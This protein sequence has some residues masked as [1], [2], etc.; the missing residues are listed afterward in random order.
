VSFFGDKRRDSV[1]WQYIMENS[2]V[3]IHGD[4]DVISVKG[5]IENALYVIKSGQVKEVD[6][7]GKALRVMKRPCHWREIFKSQSLFFY[8]LNQEPPTTCHN[9]RHLTHYWT[10][11]R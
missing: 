4:G 2:Q 9:R 1:F 5:E 10:A 7:Q 11:L 3:F 6:E 8:V